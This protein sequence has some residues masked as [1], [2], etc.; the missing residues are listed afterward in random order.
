M[1]EWYKGMRHGRGLAVFTRGF[2]YEG[3]FQYD[4]AHG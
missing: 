2:S 1:G 3:E 4:H